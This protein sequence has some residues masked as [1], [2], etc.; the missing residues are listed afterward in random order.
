M[1]IYARH[2]EQIYFLQCFLSMTRWH[3][4]VRLL[5]ICEHPRT[6]TNNAIIDTANAITDTANAIIDTAKA[7]TDTVNAITDT[8]NAIADTARAI[9]DTA[10]AITDTSRD[11]R[12]QSAVDMSVD[13]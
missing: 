2:V 1:F 11:Q 9:T 6:D 12:C 5:F 8:V 13:I 10:K 7:I 3:T 4:P